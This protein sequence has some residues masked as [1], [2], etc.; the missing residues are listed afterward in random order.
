MVGQQAGT[1]ANRRHL[2]KL[3]EGAEAWNKW[4]TEYFCPAPNLSRASFGEYA[5]PAFANLNGVNLSGAGLVRAKLGQRAST[6]RT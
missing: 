5:I 6:T 4:R 2:A 1:M 3:K